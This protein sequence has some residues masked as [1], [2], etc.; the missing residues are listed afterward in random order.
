MGFNSGFKGL[1]QILKNSGMEISMVKTKALRTSRQP[2]RVHIWYIKDNSLGNMITKDAGYKR[3]II[4]R[5]AIE[6]TVSTR[7]KL[8]SPANWA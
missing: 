7:M 5:I 4:S 6:T 1:M 8:F 2:S 3:D